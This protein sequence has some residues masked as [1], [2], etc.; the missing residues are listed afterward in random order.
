MSG[1]IIDQTAGAALRSARESVGMSQ[2][3]LGKAVHVTF[4]QIQKYEK[5]INRISI[6]KLI[7]MCNAMD[8]DPMFIIEKARTAAVELP[9][10]GL[11][12]D[13]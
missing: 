2:E 5:G 13:A 3:G 4:Q 9:E 11:P 1:N 7:L 12:A 6:S 8:I 10:T